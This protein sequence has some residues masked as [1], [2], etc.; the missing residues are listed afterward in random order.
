MILGR[1]K[2]LWAG[3]AAAVLNFIGLVIVLATNQPIS[4]ALVAVFAG[5][6]GLVLAIIGMIA[7]QSAT[8]TF[9]SRM[10][11]KGRRLGK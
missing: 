4:P 7:N 11:Y 3:L 9:I 10:S 8:G 2:E 1:A 6:N 5:A